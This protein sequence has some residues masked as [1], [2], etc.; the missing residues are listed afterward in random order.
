MN[1]FHTFSGY[2]THEARLIAVEAGR[3]NN[4]PNFKINEAV[5]LGGAAERRQQAG[6]FLEQTAK[7]GVQPTDIYNIAG[8]FAANARG[9][10][11]MNQ[12]MARGLP[13]DSFIDPYL[14]TSLNS[15]T[16]GPQEPVVF[17]GRG[18]P[19]QVI[20]P[21]SRDPGTIVPTGLTLPSGSVPGQQQFAPG[22]QGPNGTPPQRARYRDVTPVPR[23]PRVAPNGPREPLA[24]TSS[25]GA[26]LLRA[27]P[28][29]NGWTITNDATNTITAVSAAEP[30]QTI[31]AQLRL[32][33]NVAYLC[34]DGFPEYR[35]DTAAAVRDRFVT[36]IQSGEKA[37]KVNRNRIR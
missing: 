36:W 6:K 16:G 5:R 34:R 11:Q 7:L 14:G 37:A 28:I 19:E 32:R 3:P 15:F 2:S 8:Q 26:D 31:T 22:A 25:G 23:N 27:S 21:A 20:F 1:T 9:N 30:P 13:Q 24:T 33:F 35:A 4:E 18:R 12:K 10:A 17:R 29:A